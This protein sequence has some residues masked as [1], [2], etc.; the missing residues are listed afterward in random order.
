VQ[1]LKNQAIKTGLKE[2][3]IAVIEESEEGKNYR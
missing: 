1:E 3:L 2:K